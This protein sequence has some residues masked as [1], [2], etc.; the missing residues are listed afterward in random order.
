MAQYYRG[1]PGDHIGLQVKNKTENQDI[2]RIGL[3][4][5]GIVKFICG[6]SPIIPK[7]K[8]HNSDS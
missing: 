1:Q 2:K 4:K 5:V 6:E 8:C 7:N 3:V